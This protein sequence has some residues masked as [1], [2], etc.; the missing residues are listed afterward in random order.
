MPNR[1]M[2]ILRQQSA[3]IRALVDEV[4]RHASSSPRVAALLE[5]I[6]EEEERMARWLSE[7]AATPRTAV[8]LALHKCGPRE[9][10]LNAQQVHRE[11]QRQ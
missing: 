9:P 4:G 11:R 6:R 8:A 5:Q 10:L 3:F 1:P 7:S 2:T